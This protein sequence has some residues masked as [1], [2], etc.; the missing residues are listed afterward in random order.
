[1]ASNASVDALGPTRGDLVVYLNTL[2]YFQPNGNFCYL[3]ESLMDVGKRRLAKHTP[4]KASVRLATPSEV[5][6]TVKK[7]PSESPREPFDLLL[8]SM[9]KLQLMTSHDYEDLLE[10]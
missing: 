5:M 9:S 7:T 6:L 1:M 2:Y 8:E 10:S 4:S 3:Y